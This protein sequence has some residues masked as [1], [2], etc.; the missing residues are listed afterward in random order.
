ML[1][2][3]YS[4]DAIRNNLVTKPRLPLWKVKA[5]LDAESIPCY[6]IIPAHDMTEAMVKAAAMFK[7]AISIAVSMT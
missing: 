2:L 6:Y 3:V 1:N 4:A 7:K 5:V